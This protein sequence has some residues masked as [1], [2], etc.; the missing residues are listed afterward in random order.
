M[1]PLTDLI[2]R[3]RECLAG[4][5]RGYV[6]DAKDFA[7]AVLV[8]GETNANLSAVQARCTELIHAVRAACG[9]RDSRQVRV[10][11]WV[12]DVFGEVGL[13][14]HERALRFIEEA[15]EL[16][17]AEG[18]TIE[19]VSKVA[20]HVFSKE[21]GDIAQEV[22]GVGI[23][24]LAYCEVVGV[25]ADHAELTEYGRIMSLPGDYFRKRQNVKADAGIGVPVRL[26]NVVGCPVGR[27]ECGAATKEEHDRR[28]K[29]VV[30][31]G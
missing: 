19:Q 20:G 14:R 24:L 26:G 1:K 13:Y 21:K 6:E 28:E 15:I 18:L 9:S 12:E 11:M 22:G 2:A 30:Q 31:G 7:E 4:K 25:S 23:T 5:S 29:L 3:A 17:Q 27:C 8:L 10:A 16:A